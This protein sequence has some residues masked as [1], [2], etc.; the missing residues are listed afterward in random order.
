MPAC[1]AAWT[2]VHWA[3]SKAAYLAAL[4]AVM[5]DVQWVECLAASK[6]A[7]LVVYSVVHSAAW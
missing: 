4:T 7:L 2:A 1:S 5:T 3:V 6:A